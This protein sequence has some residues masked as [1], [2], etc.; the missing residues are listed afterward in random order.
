MQ[1]CMHD[2]YEDCPSR[3]QRQWVGDAYVEALVNFA[4]FGDT[5]PRAKRLV[6]QAQSQRRTA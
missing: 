1:L 4:A 6:R 3:E 5:A 2:G